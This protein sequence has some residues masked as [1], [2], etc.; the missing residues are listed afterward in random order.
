M[1]GKYYRLD[2][3]EEARTKPWTG[4]VTWVVDGETGTVYE[5]EYCMYRTVEVEI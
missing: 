5:V 3:L 4:E 2:T 1:L